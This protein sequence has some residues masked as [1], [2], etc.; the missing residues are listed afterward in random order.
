MLGGAWHVPV[1]HLFVLG[2]LLACGV[3][4]EGAATSKHHHAAVRQV[5]A[6]PLDQ[7]WGVEGPHFALKYLDPPPGEPRTSS[8]EPRADAGTSSPGASAQPASS[9]SGTGDDFLKRCLSSGYH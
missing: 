3:P 8:G 6:F 2:M 5:D 9:P 1:A 7:L 4:C